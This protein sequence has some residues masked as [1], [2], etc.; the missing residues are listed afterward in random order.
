MKIKWSLFL[1][2]SF[3]VC[4]SSCEKITG[5]G[6]MVTEFRNVTGF[7]GA[8]IDVNA[9]V[10][11]T[12]EPAYKVEVQAQQ[13]ILNVLETKLV[14]NVLVVK[15]REGK[16]LNPHDQ[17]FINI[18]AP[19]ADIVEMSGASDLYVT[20]NITGVNSSFRISGSGNM[21]VDQVNLSNKLSVNISG[22]GNIK[23]DSGLV[24]EQSLK[25]SGSGKID[26]AN[27]AA[28]KSDATIS[29]S[30]DM[31]INV[32]QQLYAAISGSGSVYYRGTPVVSTQVSGSGRV[33]PF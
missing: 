22:S 11:Y 20:G 25:I 18:S 16:R 13:N 15:L 12:V 19:A 14:G 26:L 27:L 29:G 2:L 8:R 6:P 4:F 30:G 7:N 9:R 24:K 21:Y 1:S 28:E 32:S 33:Q 3:L 23:F 31:W 17:V 10:N 5:E